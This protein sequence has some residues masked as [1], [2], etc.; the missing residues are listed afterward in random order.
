L[1]QCVLNEILGLLWCFLRL[2]CHQW[3]RHLREISLQVQKGYHA[4][5]I[6]D[7]ARWHVSKN[8]HTPKN[9]TLMPLPPYSPELNPQENV[10]Q[11]LRQNYLANKCFESLNDILDDCCR[12]WNEFAEKKGRIKSMC[13]RDWA[14]TSAY[15]LWMVSLSA[16]ARFPLWWIC[17]RIIILSNLFSVSLLR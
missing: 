12:A 14:D 7:Q 3:K 4:V 11:F 16:L 8:L 1:G 15:F 6:L 5:V 13:S 9:I 17:E 10:W 2:I